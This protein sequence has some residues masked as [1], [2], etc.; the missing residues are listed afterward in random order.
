MKLITIEKSA[1]QNGH[2]IAGSMKLEGFASMDIVIKRTR[3]YI[4]YY[5]TSTIL[6]RHNGET[7]GSRKGLHLS[8][9]GR[10]ERYDTQ[11][12]LIAAIERYI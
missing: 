12:E 2:K 10:Q 1:I 6:T 4:R 8:I 7:M 3:L 11:R 9:N 5:P